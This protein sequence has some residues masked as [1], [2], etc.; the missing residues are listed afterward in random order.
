[1]LT[2]FSEFDMFYSTF[3][4]IGYFLFLLYIGK[5]YSNMNI[6]VSKIFFYINLS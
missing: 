2:I 6:L 1:M 3:G 5:I 4:Q